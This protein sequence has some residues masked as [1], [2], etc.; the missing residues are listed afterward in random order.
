[1]MLAVQLRPPA[2][3]RPRPRIAPSLLMVLSPLACRAHR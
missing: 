2:S 1:M 3:T